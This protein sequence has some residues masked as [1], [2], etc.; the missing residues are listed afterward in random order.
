MGAS[1]DHTKSAVRIRLGRWS[2]GV[3]RQ[4]QGVPPDK[5]SHPEVAHKASREETNDPAICRFT[6]GARHIQR[7]GSMVW[8]AWVRLSAHQHSEMPFGGLT[9]F[10]EYQG[11]NGSFCLGLP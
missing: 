3:T 2:P 5:V 4:A 6:D 9:G 10:M 8:L 11:G 1:K 7:N